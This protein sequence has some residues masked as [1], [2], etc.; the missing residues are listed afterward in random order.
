MTNCDI[1]LL[2][3]AV[4]SKQLH[5][6]KYLKKTIKLKIIIEFF[7]EI[8]LL[9]IKLSSSPIESLIYCKFY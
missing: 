9:A 5:R 6:Q 1:P 4:T 8:S 2:Y 7:L 3:T